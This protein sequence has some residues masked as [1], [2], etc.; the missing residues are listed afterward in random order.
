ARAAADLALA[1]WRALGCRDGGRVD[2]RLDGAGRPAFIEVNPL[3][4]LNPEHSDLPIM[5]ALAGN[6]Y[7]ALV[8]AIV[9]SALQRLPRE[10]ARP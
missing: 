4:G 8:A 10:G 6:D 9:E 2:V 7:G 3:P 1:S 5:W